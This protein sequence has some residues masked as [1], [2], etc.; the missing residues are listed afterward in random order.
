[1]SG[2]V[3]ELAA[4]IGARRKRLRL[5]MGDRSQ[6]LSEFLL[7]AG[8]VLGSLGLLLQPW[9]AGAAPWGFAVPLVFVLGYLAIELR[10]RASAASGDSEGAARVQAG[11]DWAIVLW[12]MTCA[13]AGIAAFVIAWGA[14]PAPPAEPEGWTPPESSVSVD[15]V[16]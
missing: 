1:M 3:T 15:I 2:L 4:E 5:A 8:L 16:P 6:A 7:L 12:G 14:E 11:Y 9:M 10:R 13:L